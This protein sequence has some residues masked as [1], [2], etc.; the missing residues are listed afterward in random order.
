VGAIV[1]NKELLVKTLEEHMGISVEDQPK[2]SK[3]GHNRMVL[4]QGIM[5]L[6]LIY[7]D[8]L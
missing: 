5:R 4:R 2:K 6:G 3:K 8:E 7:Y 1:M